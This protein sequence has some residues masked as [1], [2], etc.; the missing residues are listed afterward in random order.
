MNM[1][2]QLVDLVLDR[3]TRMGKKWH[4]DYSVIRVIRSRW[5]DLSHVDQ[6]RFKRDVKQELGEY[7]TVL[8]R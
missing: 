4:I 6:L 2:D 3:T 5:S 7:P 8:P 1:V